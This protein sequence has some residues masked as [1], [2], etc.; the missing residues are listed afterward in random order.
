MKKCSECG[1]NKP[2]IEFAKSKHAKDGFQY[3]CKV[4]SRQLSKNWYRKNADKQIAKTKAK[5]AENP[6]AARNATLLRKYG[7]TLAERNEMLQKQNGCCAIC[8]EKLQNIKVDHCHKT[9][10][11]RE[12]LCHNCN[13]LLGLAK[14][15]VVTLQ[16]AVRYL[17]KHTHLHTG[18]LQ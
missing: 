18:D 2:L 13:V 10:K 11:I 6:D 7:I 14:D 15:K 12:L 1:E 8:N 16:N 17:Q 9:N 4:C 3:L 5:Y